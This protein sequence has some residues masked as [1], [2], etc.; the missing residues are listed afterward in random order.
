MFNVLT[1]AYLET[2]SIHCRKWRLV[3]V[4]PDNFFIFIYHFRIH[5]VVQALH[6]IKGISK[7][8]AFPPSAH[9]WDMEDR[10][11]GRELGKKQF[12]FITSVLDTDLC[13]SDSLSKKDLLPPGCAKCLQP[14]VC[15]IKCLKLCLSCGELNNLR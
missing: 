12:L 11:Y 14:T 5:E 6:V 15:S 7:R 13:C 10:E 4:F 1:G 8:Y 2:K 9:I 3:I